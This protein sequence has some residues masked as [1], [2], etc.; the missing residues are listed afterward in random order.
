[1]TNADRQRLGREVR[2]D[3]AVV[4]GGLGARLLVAFLTALAGGEAFHAVESD[5]SLPDG[6]YWAITT[7]TT[8]GVSPMP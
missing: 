8:V 7:M 4:V 2:H 3:P 1:M 6:V 5:V